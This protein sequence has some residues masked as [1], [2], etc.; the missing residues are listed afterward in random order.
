M[1]VP[2]RV[3][4]D[5]LRPL[6]FM[7]AVD[8][9]ELQ[10]LSNAAHRVV[11]E[12]GEHLFHY[13][14]RAEWV[15]YTLSG[16]GVMVW[17]GPTNVNTAIIVSP[18]T[19]AGVYSIVSLDTTAANAT[20]ETNVSAITGMEF[21]AITWEQAYRS[22]RKGGTLPAALMRIHIWMAMQG[23]RQMQRM[24]LRP[25]SI[26]VACILTELHNMIG[27]RID[28]TQFLLADLCGATRE[29]VGD[30]LRRMQ[31][32]GLINNGRGW[33]EVL[34]PDA[35]KAISTHYGHTDPLPHD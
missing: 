6:P 11:L 4:V 29:A 35:V 22:V 19:L 2:R 32:E 15:F 23:L 18:G 27:A 10:D 20:Y 14:E 8:E 26:R 21:A 24:V 5:E 9:E 7:D 13:G 17:P 3:T 1:P 12:P 31:R 16:A 30:V 25:V 34:D 33:V 28:V